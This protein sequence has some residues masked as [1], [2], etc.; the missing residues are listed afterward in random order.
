[1]VALKP[2]HHKPPQ[3]LYARGGHGCGSVKASLLIVGQSNTPCAPRVGPEHAML[4]SLL[5]RLPFRQSVWFKFLVFLVKRF[6][7]DQCRDKAGS[8]TYTTMLSLVPILTVFLVIV[9]SIPALA[10]ARAEI[11]SVIYRNLLPQSSVQVS[12]Y[13]S[14][15]ADK[16]SNLTALGVLFLFITA[17][18]M[19]TTIEQS[20]NQIWRV[21]RPRT[22]L[23][24]FLRYW[25]IISLGPILLG[26]ALVLSSALTSIEF[27]NQ[28]F[29]GYAIDWSIW[30]RLAS[31]LLTVAGFT[32]VY[33]LI[34]NCKVPLRESAI[35]ALVVTL[36]FGLLKYSFGFLMANFTSYNQVYGAF[37]ALPIFLLWIYLTW[38]LVLLGVEITYALTVFHSADHLP[39]HPVLAI[40]DVLKLFHERHQIGAEVI[41]TEAMS[42]L[43]RTEVDHW[44][45]YAEVLHT[46]NII[47]KTEAGGY[48]LSK[49]LDQVDFWQ[50]Y[51]QLPF[52]LPRREDLGKVLADDTWVQV[53][54]PQLVQ[55][56]EYLSAKL[57]IP[58]S[59]IFSS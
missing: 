34:P 36:L 52:P 29:N 25:A 31:V 2:T 58:L 43:G 17:L 46:Q 3:K 40:L 1:M 5:S 27:L 18:L 32:F 9:S 20:F 24:A 37:A 42:V 16:S 45:E 49:N 21:K 11:Q 54:G 12:E 38:N 26:S 41:D 39:R 44:P 48:V 33:W 15:F 13:L 47:R 7:T 56:D 4:N 28:N 22:G 59:R 50:F 30:L 57:S 23:V 8:L 53:I 55:S 51:K 10:P 6:E 14:E 19:L 35:A